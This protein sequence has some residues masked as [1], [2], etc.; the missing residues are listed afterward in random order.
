MDAYSCGIDGSS[1]QM[2][3]SGITTYSAKA[4]LASTPMIFTCWQMW[5][6]P[7]R[8]CRHLPHA[9]CISAETKSPSFTL[10]T[11]LPTAS[12]MPQNSCPGMSG[13]W[14]RRC[15]HW[16]HLI[17]VQVGAA[18]GSNLHPNEDIRG[19]E[20]RLGDFANFTAGSR[21][22]L[23]YGKHGI[24]H[25]EDSLAAMTGGNSSAQYGGKVVGKRM[26]LAR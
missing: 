10:V 23:Y 13:G 26:I 15:A 22:R 11:S 4:P 12:T 3:D 5:A 9:T 20:L 16:S 19:P 18:D 2:L 24:R 17:D 8:H 21:S 14:I 25:E 1:F 7:M 6:S